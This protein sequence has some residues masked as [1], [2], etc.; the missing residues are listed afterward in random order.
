M[1]DADFYLLDEVIELICLPDSFARQ[2]YEISITFF[3]DEAEQS[4]ITNFSGYSAETINE[5]IKKDFDFLKSQNLVPRTIIIKQP[6]NWII[7]TSF[8]LQ[9]NGLYDILFKWD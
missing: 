7:E 9:D 5:K 2:I 8:I 3:K 6:E 1:V 4:I